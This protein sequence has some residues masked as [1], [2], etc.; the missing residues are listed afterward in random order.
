MPFT[1]VT[2]NLLAPIHVRPE[3]YP[4]VP[5]DLLDGP[6]RLRRILARLRALDPDVIA[7]QEVEPEG[8]GFLQ[9]GLRDREYDWRLTLKQQ[10]R[11]EGVALFV[12]RSLFGLVRFEEIF[13]KDAGPDISPT[14][15][16]AILAQGTYEGRPI[17][18]GTTHIKWELPEVTPD[19]HR[20]VM[21]TTQL[22]ARLRGAGPA[23]ISGDF[24]A[25]ANS[26]VLAPLWAAGFRDP[27]AALDQPTGVFNNHAS[28]ID[29]LVHSP[30]LT[31]TANRLPA[32][33]GESLLPSPEEPSDHLMLRAT[34]RW[35]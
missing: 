19:R 2:W 15:N 11:L 10:Y 32:L 9:D 25:T 18:L 35:A 6:T 17:L 27:F 24:N 13:Y 14:G 31:A 26:P 33:T 23:V 20:G 30:E 34:L 29:F 1:F 3:R 21:Q 16:V 12:R 4:G 7:L 5:A 8:C 28:R 22:A